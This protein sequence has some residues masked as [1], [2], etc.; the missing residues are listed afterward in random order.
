MESAHQCSGACLLLFW[1]ILKGLL[2]SRCV[3]SF[4]RFIILRWSLSVSYFS[5]TRFI[6]DDLYTNA[7]PWNALDLCEVEKLNQVLASHVF[8]VGFVTSSLGCSAIVTGH[9]V[10]LAGLWYVHEPIKIQPRWYCVGESMLVPL[11]NT[12]TF[13]NNCWLREL[14]QL[15]EAYQL[16]HLS[17]W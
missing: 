8:I 13:I 15:S 11:F 6:S 4:S 16:F 2:T 7:I 5:V 14:I 1:K 17:T 10:S 3:T 9:N 12:M